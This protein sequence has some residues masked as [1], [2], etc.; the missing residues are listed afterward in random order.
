MKL[1]DTL[2][3]QRV[4]EDMLEHS[5]PRFPASCAG[6]DYLL[7]T[8]FRY[9]PYRQGSRFRRADQ[10]E[11]CFYASIEVDTAIAELAFYR[12]LFFLEAPGMTLPRN[13][14]EHTAFSVEVDAAATIDLT[15]LPLNRDASAWTD[16]IEYGPC[17]TLA[18]ATRQSG[19]GA[20]RYRSV[21]DPQLGINVALLDPASLATRKP[22]N[23][24]T[25]HLFVGRQAV[26][27]F[28]EM[29]RDALEFKIGI[30]AGD[31]RIA[32]IINTT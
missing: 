19:T 26:Q 4:L 17:Q 15:E 6:L 22:D 7:A 9:Y 32:G 23:L 10:T 31:P 1:V 30:W 21:R 29:R 28:S 12:L 3:E 8:P 16:P 2:N 5:K 25:W 14:L 20:I 11:G 18:D 24:Q 27:A 13:G